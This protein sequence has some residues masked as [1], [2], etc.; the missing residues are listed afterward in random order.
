MDKKDK[1]R[2]NDDYLKEL[3]GNG[4]GGGNDL[5][6]VPPIDLTY[7][8]PSIEY[9]NIHIDI[10][11]SGMFYK[12]GTKISIRSAKVSEIQAYSMVDENNFV[13][14]TEKM[15]DILSR[16]VRFTHPDGTKGSYKNIKD[17]DR[18]FLIFMIRELTFQGGNT[19]TKEVVCNDCG[20]EFMI[21]FRATPGLE[22]PSTFELHDPNEKI[23]KFYKKD[24]RVYELIH[25]EVSWKLSP[26][27]IGIQEDFYEE[28]KRNVQ[29][30]KKP[31]I[32]FMKVMPFLL[33]DRSTITE[34]GIKAKQKDFKDMND[35]V[36]SQGLDEVINNMTVGIKGLKMKCP[37]CSVEVY[38]DMTFPSGASTLFKIPDILGKFG[39]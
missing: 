27:T 29:I 36:L 6:T 23:E 28:I 1:E 18:I 5:P 9:K 31:N 14:I 39:V 8:A 19:L 4:D 12:S 35:L 10:L 17:S 24:E 20:H 22:V 13:D 33:Y 26:P 15:N 11:P 7:D 37:E 21:P 2:K 3:L 38:T 25:K 32:A 30:D 34:E 16:N